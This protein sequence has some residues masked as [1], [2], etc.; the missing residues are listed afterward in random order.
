M[1]CAPIPT[2]DDHG[3]P[4]C[5]VCNKPVDEVQSDRCTLSGDMILTAVCHGKREVV[6]LTQ[7]EALQITFGFRLETAFADEA[8][9]KARPLLTEGR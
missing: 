5:A 1:R 3:Y 4:T 7:R 8:A 2:L 9:A 6:R